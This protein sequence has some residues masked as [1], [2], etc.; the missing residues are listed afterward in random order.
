MRLFFLILLSLGGAGLG[1]GEDAD[2]EAAD[3][4]Y[5]ASYFYAASLAASHQGHDAES[6]VL[7]K[8]ACDSDPQ[9]LFLLRELAESYEG[10][11]RNAEAQEAL[12]RALALAPGD[13][14]LRQKLARLYLRSGKNAQ[15][16]AL[17]GRKG[18]EPKDRFSLKALAALDMAEGKWE[19]ACARLEALLALYPLA[20]EER[21]MLAGAL[22]RL[23]RNEE[24]ARHYEN[25]FKEDSSRAE[26]AYRLSRLYEELE[27][28]ERAAAVLKEAAKASP[29]SSLIQDAL[30]R[31]YYRQEKYKEAEEAFSRLLEAAPTDADSLLYRGMSRLQSKKFKEAQSDFQSLGELEGANP[32]QL[33]GLGLAQLWQEQKQEAEATFKKLVEMHP[34]AV[35]GYTQLAFIYDR[36]SRTAE[37]AEV[38]ARGVEQNPDS[39]EMVLLLASAYMDLGELRR[40]ETALIKG[41]QGLD[42]NSSLRFQLAVLYDKGGEFPKAEDQ[43]V[44]II[45]AEPENAQALNYLG[46]SWVERD[47]KLGE[48]E[49]L[50][51]RALK[52]EPDNH[53]YQDSLGWACYKLGRYDEAREALTKAAAAITQAGA[54][55]AVVFE[56][57]ARTYEK[58]GDRRKARANFDKAGELKGK[59]A[60][61]AR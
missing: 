20:Q 33:Y 34:K 15:A 50:I 49:A 47:H 3:R 11:N 41:I 4:S 18:E 61:D 42:G 25:L 8:R 5:R 56:H 12:A 27:Q 22:A 37:A 53:Y 16:R 36:S 9:S 2:F 45:A 35:P 40:A 30:A 38:L 19:A 14:E 60:T 39:S 21:E 17:F 59:A 28:G 55:E 32:S 24:A 52:Q 58:L 43:L 26:T 23:G 54:E 10:L 46:Y 57:L 48:A 51:R 6:L 31:A 29:G 13:G 7:L 44:K 1:A